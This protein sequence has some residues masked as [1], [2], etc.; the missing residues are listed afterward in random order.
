MQAVLMCIQ[1]AVRTYLRAPSSFRAQRLLALFRHW[2]L[3]VDRVLFRV[4][5]HSFLPLQCLHQSLSGIL[6]ATNQQRPSIARADSH[7]RRKAAIIR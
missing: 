6:K 3:T 1:L 2:A 4:P 5:A 7:S